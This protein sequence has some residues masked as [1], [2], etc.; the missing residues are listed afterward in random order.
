MTSTA[1]IPNT[2]SEL[3]AQLVTSAEAQEI[4]A[5]LLTLQTLGLSK[6]D[7]TV[8]LERMRATNDATAQSE[9]TEENCLLALDM[10]YGL[11]LPSISL[12]WDAA[13]EC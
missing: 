3:R 5:S 13:E 4:F 1:P 11:V 10:V 6:M 8:H 9:L 12:V 7:L 2:L